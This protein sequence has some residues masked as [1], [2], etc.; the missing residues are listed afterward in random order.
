MAAVDA[1]YHGGDGGN[2]P[3]R[4]PRKVARRCET[5]KNYYFI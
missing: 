3:P 2:D 5:G 1:R 4:R